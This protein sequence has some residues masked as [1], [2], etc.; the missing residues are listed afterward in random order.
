MNNDDDCIFVIILLVIRPWDQPWARSNTWFNDSYLST[1]MLL[2]R[3]DAFNE[4]RQG[5]W[6]CVGHRH[7]EG[8]GEYTTTLETR[9]EVYT[10]HKPLEGVLLPESPPRVLRDPPS[11]QCLTLTFAR[12]ASHHFSPD[13]HSQS[14]GAFSTN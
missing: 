5:Q 14:K 7:Q 2:R 1:R 10:R 13:C 11:I 3:G 9:T 4:V 8:T 12:G 6:Y